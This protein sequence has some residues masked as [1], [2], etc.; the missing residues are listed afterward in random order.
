MGLVSDQPPY[1]ADDAP[2]SSVATDKVHTTD[3]EVPDV[4]GVRAGGEPAD[5]QPAAE[6]VISEPSAA[7]HAETGT[8]VPPDWAVRSWVRHPRLEVVLGARMADITWDVIANLVARKAPEDQSLDFKRDMYVLDKAVAADTLPGKE[9]NVVDARIAKDRYELCK[10][11]TALANSA[12]G[13]IVIGVAEHSGRGEK[14][15]PVALE[16]SRRLLIR[17]TI[18]SQVTPLVTGVEVGHLPSPEDPAG[19]LV[20]I[21]VPSSPDSPHA[22]VE[23]NTHRHTWYVRDGARAVP[24]S[25]PQIALAYRDR[26]AGRADLERLVGTVFDDGVAELDRVEKVWLAV[27]AVPTKA[28][29]SRLLDRHLMEEF[30]TQIG[31]RQTHLPGR[32]AML[33]HHAAYGRGR[34]VLRDARPNPVADDH[35]VHLY[36]DGRAFAA[37]SLDTLVDT[38][39]VLRGQP[40]LRPDTVCVRVGGLTVWALNLIGMVAGHAVDA[41]SSGDL[42]LLCGIVTAVEPDT[43]MFGGSQTAP[44][45]LQHVIVDTPW[46][47]GQPENMIAGTHARTAVTPVQ[48]TA[49]PVVSSDLR[50][51]VAVTAQVINEIVAEFG[52]LPSD[53]IF[54]GDGLIDGAHCEGSPT[55]HHWAE[56]NNL[57][58]RQHPTAAN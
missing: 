26:F 42:E 58:T 1:V 14:V 39:H 5:D 33:G 29:L 45:P 44:A 49:S 8:A 46:R 35:L 53:P 22:V 18:F 25:E 36:T 19:G 37:L 9:K 41:G 30:K 15:L 54:T 13:L 21:F 51:L 4:T 7:S 23:R 40:M 27:A 52:Q 48:V 3:V 56:T 20:L 12:G 50:E 34:I 10:D 6:A 11:V 43:D 31:V 16:D 17:D 28:A 32:S 55:L 24:L 47:A 38:A 2:V 57:L